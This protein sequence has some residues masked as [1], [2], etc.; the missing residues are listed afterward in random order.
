M[1]SSIDCNILTHLERIHVFIQ[2]HR[3]T[4]M[5]S[6]GSDARVQKYVHEV[7][8]NFPRPLV[9]GR[10]LDQGKSFNWTKSD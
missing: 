4:Y 9:A 1:Y 8:K 7:S 6:N 5:L 10:F 3:H 2:V